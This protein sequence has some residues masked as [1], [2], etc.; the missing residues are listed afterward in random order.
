MS[1]GL[2]HIKNWLSRATPDYYTMFVKAW[3]PL[4]AWYVHEYNTQEDRVAIEK[5]RGERNKI[6][7]R[8]EALLTNTDLESKTFKLHLAHL[9]LQLEERNIYHRE[10]KLSFNEIKLDQG[11]G[12]DPSSEVDKAGNVYVASAEK[13]FFHL[14]I[15]REKGKGKSL[16]DKKFNQ[17]SLEE[18]LKDS[19]YIGL[20]NKLMQ[21]KIRLCYQKIDPNNS[22][23][24]IA[25]PKA[26]KI[27]LDADSR[28]NFVD[29][30]E[31]I[32]KSLIQI[33]YTLRCAL[34]HGEIDPTETNQG[35]YEHAFYLL[36]CIIKEL[37]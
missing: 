7:N 15:I 3:I 35:I 26:D 33:I 37:H 12:I 36:K 2:L 34:F 6:R 18:L 31:L 27:I 28:I 25:K 19:Q 23:S 13:G 30:P 14:R 21:E 10:H 16:M 24:L 1:S 22:V 11:E 4:N 9:H 20:N 32:A 29:N 5:L 17:H 8:I